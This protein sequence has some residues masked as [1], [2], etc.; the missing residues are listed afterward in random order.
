MTPEG[1]IFGEDNKQ[2]Q[3]LTVDIRNNK[4]TVHSAHR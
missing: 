1:I 4:S 2:F 3:Y